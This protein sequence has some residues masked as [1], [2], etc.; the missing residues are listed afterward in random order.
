MLGKS[1]DS[2]T[3]SPAMMKKNPLTWENESA[4]GLNQGTNFLFPLTEFD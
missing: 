2:L 3:N 1:P 4:Q